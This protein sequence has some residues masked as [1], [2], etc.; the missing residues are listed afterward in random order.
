[1]RNFQSQMNT[2]DRDYGQGEISNA[3]MNMQ[4]Y[5]HILS[6]LKN[7]CLNNYKINIKD[8]IQKRC[9]CSTLWVHITTDLRKSNAQKNGRQVTMSSVLTPWLYRVYIQSYN[10]WKI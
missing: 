3:E 1:M 5:P 6:Q 7:A 4:I 8:M 10:G 9:M 2:H